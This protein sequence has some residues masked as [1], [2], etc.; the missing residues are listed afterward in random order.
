MMLSPENYYDIHLKGKS[1]R[2]IKAAIRGLKNEIGRLKNSIE[3]AR[4]CRKVGKIEIRPS[5]STQIFYMRE[6]IKRAKQALEELGGMYIPS[7]AERKATKF[8]ERIPFI[9]TIIFEIGGYF[10]GITKYTLEFAEMYARLTSEKPRDGLFEEKIVD[11]DEILYLLGRLYMANGEGSIA[12]N[13]TEK[14]C[15]T[16]SNGAL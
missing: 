15:V 10:S 13:D 3:S 1:E 7:K 8:L 14:A 4:Y 6:Y 16:G 12:L 2:Q 11:K 5:E 9:S